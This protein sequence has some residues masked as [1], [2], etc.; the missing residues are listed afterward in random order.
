MFSLLPSQL[1]IIIAKVCLKHKK[2]LV[3]A[4]YIS[5][6][7]MTLN[8]QFKEAKLICLN[9]IGL[10]PGI[11]HLEAKKVIDEVH[12][13]GGKIR[14]FV[15]W[16]GGVPLPEFSG[17]PFGY[18]FSWSPRGV[19]SAALKDAKYLQDGRVVSIPGGNLFKSRQAVNIF[20]GFNLEGK[21]TSY[22]CC[23]LTEKKKGIPNRDSL[24]YG[25][26]YGIENE[27][28]TIF[29]GTLRYQGF[30][31]LMEALVEIGL[32]DETKQ[33]Y[34]KK[35]SPK[36]TWVKKKINFLN[37]LKFSLFKN[38]ALRK[39]LNVEDQPNISTKKALLKRLDTPFG[40]PF[41]G[42]T[43][44]QITRIL[45]ALDW[46]GI[47]SDEP[48]PLLGTFSDA[49][50]EVMQSKMAYQPHEND[51]ILLHHIFGIE[52]PN[53]K[54]ETRTATLVV[55]GTSRASAM[56]RTV[57]I[58]VALATELVMDGIVSAPGVI[59]PLSK[60][61]Y[62]PLLKSLVNEGIEFFLRSE[63]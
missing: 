20:P 48:I 51:M 54:Y 27:A 7:L 42:Y 50:T 23:K 59:A 46:L 12:E 62:V 44:D 30:C 43:D 37:M 5:P 11:D 61:I 18:K 13:Q 10:D 38:Q 16:C 26:E 47:F 1:N 28:V 24:I 22:V 25:K 39:L 60:E 56:S 21:S 2:H 8:D 63:K 6:E 3:T 41:K 14:Q 49:L 57:G 17:N 55:H 58:P 29:R 52:W 53:G 40:F 15:S 31:E 34:L 4:S 36:I 9:E 32:V 45:D 35:D 33:P 19:L